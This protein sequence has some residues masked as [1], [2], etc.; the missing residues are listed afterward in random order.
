MNTQ[1]EENTLYTISAL[2]SRQVGNYVKLKMFAEKNILWTQGNE[3]ADI[4]GVSRR[5]AYYTLNDLKKV[6]L[7]RIDWSS[8]NCKFIKIYFER[9]L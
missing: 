3:V 5:Q 1:F 8:Q 6:R 2:T 9:E 7:I 4:L